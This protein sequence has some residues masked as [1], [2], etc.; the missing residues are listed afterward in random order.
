MDHPEY[1]L[2]THTIHAIPFVYVRNLGYVGAVSE[3]FIESVVVERTAEPVVCRD[4]AEQLLAGK[5]DT[6][7]P[8]VALE[9][10][11]VETT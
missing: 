8:T 11:L 6:F 7:P 10:S 9:K 3:H 2:M 1:D 4:E 5:I